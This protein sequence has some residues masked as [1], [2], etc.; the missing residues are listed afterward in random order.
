MKGGEGLWGG[1]GEGRSQTWGG[2]LWAWYRL[3]CW[4]WADLFNGNIFKVTF[5]TSESWTQCFQMGK[6]WLNVFSWSVALLTKGVCFHLPRLD[7][8]PTYGGNHEIKLSVDWLIDWLAGW[9]VDQLINALTAELAPHQFIRHP[10]YSCSDQFDLFPKLEWGNLPQTQSSP[11]WSQNHP[12]RG[13]WHKLMT[14]SL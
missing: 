4:K 14:L 12:T 13:N 6:S 8:W 10:N 1:V 7:M 9:L 11:S 3:A 2:G 5:E